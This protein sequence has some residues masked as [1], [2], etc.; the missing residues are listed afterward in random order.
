MSK[1]ANRQPIRID[2]LFAGPGARG[3]QW[4]NLVELALANLPDE[5]YED[6]GRGVRSIARGYR[7]AYEASK[8]A[9]R[10]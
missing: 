8:I 5:A 9:S 4:R 7:D 3:D 2:Q 10:E 6:I 1:G